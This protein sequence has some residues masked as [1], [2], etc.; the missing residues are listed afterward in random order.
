[1]IKRLANRED[2][3]QAVDDLTKALDL[4]GE[5][6]N[7][8]YLLPNGVDS[9]KKAFGH[10]RVLTSKVF[11][12]ANLNNSGNYDAAIIF[13]KNK[14]PRHGVEIFS[15]YIWLSSNPRAGYK[16]LA[17]AIKFARENGFEFIQMG[18]SEK[19]PNKDKVKSLYKKLGFL[20]DSE[21]YIAKL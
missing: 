12:W 10:S 15:E 4:E 16:L 1:M 7:Y 2:F 3:C 5:D 6:K 17:T 20:K 18:C 19:S 8:H 21:T 11:V 14:D 9:I 13:L